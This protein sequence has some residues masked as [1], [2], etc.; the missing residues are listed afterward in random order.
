M[1]STPARTGQPESAEAPRTATDDLTLPQPI[2][3]VLAASSGNLVEWFDFHVYATFSVY[4]ASE[5]F[6]PVRRPRSS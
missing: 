5:F 2:R 3:L 4:F 1:A 6:R